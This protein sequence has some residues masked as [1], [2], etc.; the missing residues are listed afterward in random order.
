MKKIFILCFAIIAICFCSCSPTYYN[1]K[2]DIS[3][4]SNDGNVIQQWNNATIQQGNT[5]VGNYNTP[6]KNGGLE[7]ATAQGEQMYIN[8]GIIIV[9]NI[10]QN[11]YE[12]NTTTDSKNY[13]VTSN[14]N[15]SNTNVNELVENYYNIKKQ[16][17][18]NKKVLR[19]LSVESDLYKE[20][21]IKILNLQTQ[22]KEIE[23]KYYEITNYSIYQHDKYL[24][25]H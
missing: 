13:T 21:N 23:Q 10:K 17:R 2:G 5:Y 16:I 14:I 24:Q 7:F 1:Y 8:G 22:L 20:V 3:L 12:N 4:M 6:Y 25:T 19:S 9:R 11:L 15:T 18:L